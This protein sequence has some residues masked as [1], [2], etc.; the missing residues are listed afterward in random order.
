MYW[1]YD[2]EK[3]ETEGTVEVIIAKNFPK[4]MTNTKTQ[5]RISN[6]IKPENMCTYI[7]NI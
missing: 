3:K 2:E 6:N 4:L 1:K 5:I 7:Y